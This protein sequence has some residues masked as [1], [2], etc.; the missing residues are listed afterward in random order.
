MPPVYVNLIND[1]MEIKGRWYSCVL[2]RAK[3]EADSLKRS[4]L[5]VQGS[6]IYRSEFCTKRQSFV[7][8]LVVPKDLRK[9]ILDK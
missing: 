7:W 4:C 6:Q 3:N 9:S 2:D 8:K 1:S 5:R